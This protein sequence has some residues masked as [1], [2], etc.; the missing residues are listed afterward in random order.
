LGLARARDLTGAKVR[1]SCDTDFYDEHLEPQ[2]FTRGET[3]A[4]FV[5]DQHF[6]AHFFSKAAH[7]N[8]IYQESLPLRSA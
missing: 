6:F 3:F 7:L 2:H 1:S 5:P 8:G 4:L